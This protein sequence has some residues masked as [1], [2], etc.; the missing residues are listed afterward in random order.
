MERT[1]LHSVEFLNDGIIDSLTQ[2]MAPGLFHDNLKREISRS[3]REDQELT[4]LSITL[5]PT[6][7]ESL[8]RYEKAL[9]EIAHDLRSQLRGGEFFA[10]ISDDGFWLLLRSSEAEAEKV[11]DRLDIR[12][13]DRLMHVVLA[14]EHDHYEDW[15]RKMDA[16]H[17]NGA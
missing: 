7:F 15:I 3:E 4:I 16:L 10:R 13:S 8:S 1:E 6:D 2:T 12:Y 17:F 14:R 9:I 11:M 5:A